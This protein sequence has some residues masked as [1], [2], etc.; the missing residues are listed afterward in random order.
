MT[1]D[2]RWMVGGLVTVDLDG[3]PVTARIVRAPLD[4]DDDEWVRP[5]FNAW[6][7]DVLDVEG[8]TGCVVRDGKIVA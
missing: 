1:T 8:M 3:S 6:I 4:H 2:E 7:V 5:Y